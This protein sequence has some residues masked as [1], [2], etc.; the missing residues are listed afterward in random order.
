MCKVKIMGILNVTPDSFSDGGLYQNFKQ[1]TQYAQ[2]MIDDGADIIDVGGE[3]SRPNA[4]KISLDQELERVIPVIEAIR[5]N[6]DVAISID[7]YKPEVMVEAV[8]VGATMINDIYGATKPNTI[9]TMA[10]LKVDVC[11]M[12]M[13]GTP[14]TMQDNPDYQDVTKEVLFFLK[15]QIDLLVKEGVAKTKITI[16]PGFGFGKTQQHNQQLFQQ[17]SQFK[18]LNCPIL[19]GLS[20]KSMIGNIINEQTTDKRMTASVIAAILGVQ[21]GANIIRTHDVKETKNGLKILENLNSEELY[22]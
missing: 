18:Q 17:L 2:K 20:R 15:Q 14:Q 13:Q 21:K 22:D 6:S 9:A 11:L 3:S 4:Q 1:A 19:I 12:H 5:K 8:N 7:T 16:D 10:K